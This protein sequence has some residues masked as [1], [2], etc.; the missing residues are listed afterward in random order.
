MVSCVIFVSFF[1]AEDYTNVFGVSISLRLSNV[2]WCI[3]KFDI[4]IGQDD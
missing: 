1:F 2:L 4:D 3:I